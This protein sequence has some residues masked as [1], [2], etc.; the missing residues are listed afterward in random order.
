MTRRVSS[1]WRREKRR[2]ERKYYWSSPQV[3]KKRRE[4]SR[5]HYY[6]NKTPY[7]QRAK[8]WGQDHP[9]KRKR[10]ANKYY[11]RN[12]EKMH[13]IGRRYVDNLR[14]LVFGHYS[15]NL[16]CQRC[17]FSDIRALSIDHIAGG[18]LA[19]ARQLGHKN[20]RGGTNLYRWIR[21]NGFPTGFQVLCM[22]CQFIKRHEN[23][24]CTGAGR[25]KEYIPVA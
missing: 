17:G 22:N 20:M 8:K 3:T 12:V 15:P 6:K 16:V 11:W 19:H 7:I 14:K 9:I 5:A 10:I 21:D 25:I 13:E 18:G 1:E 24:E 23:N 4:N 2:R